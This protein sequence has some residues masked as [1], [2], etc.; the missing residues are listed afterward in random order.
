MIVKS[1][2][3][4]AKPTCRHEHLEEPGA[5]PRRCEVCNHDEFTYHGGKYDYSDE[6]ASK[7]LIGD[8][9]GRYFSR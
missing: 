8:A 2:Y 7:P 5:C 9:D 4:C 1:V 3:R 6:P